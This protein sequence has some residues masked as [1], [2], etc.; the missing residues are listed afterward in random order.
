[1][2]TQ[3]LDF[4][5]K[6]YELVEHSKLAILETFSSPVRKGLK[7]ENVRKRT[8]LTVIVCPHRVWVSINVIPTE[9]AYESRNRPLT[10]KKSAGKSLLFEKGRG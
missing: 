7:I 9:I 1:M 2:D 6:L 5:R 4:R 10:T 3:F 8:Q